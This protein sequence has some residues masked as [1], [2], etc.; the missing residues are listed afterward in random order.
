M[1][2]ENCKALIKVEKKHKHVFQKI[3]NIFLKENIENEDR[4]FVAITL[5]IY[6]SIVCI[7]CC[8]HEPWEDEAQAWLIARDLSPIEIVKQMRFEGCGIL[9]YCHLQN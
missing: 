6:T 9:C 5:I 1:N 7:A 8:F 3:Y 2:E 4:L